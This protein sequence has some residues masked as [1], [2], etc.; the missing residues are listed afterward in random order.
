MNEELPVFLWRKALMVI[1]RTDPYVGDPGPGI[2]TSG[3]DGWV[4]VGSILVETGY[5]VQQ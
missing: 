4:R 2:E 1:K 5:T 3:W